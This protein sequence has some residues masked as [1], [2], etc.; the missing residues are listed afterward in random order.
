MVALLEP[1]SRPRQPCSSDKWS[2]LPYGDVSLYPPLLVLLIYSVYQCYGSAPCIIPSTRHR[3]LHHLASVQHL[4]WSPFVT[5]QAL[6]AM[7]YRL[8]LEKRLRLVHVPIEQNRRTDPFVCPYFQRAFSV[9][10]Q[11]L[12]SCKTG[13]SIFSDLTTI[14][15]T[16]GGMP[17]LTRHRPCMPLTDDAD[18]VPV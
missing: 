8:Q 15:W 18:I 11:F 17:V 7:T 16:G 2:L 10:R 1:R 6:E 4:S 13:A 14:R 5:S 12:F 9:R 3:F